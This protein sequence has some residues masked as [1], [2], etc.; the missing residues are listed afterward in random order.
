MC[1]RKEKQLEL[2]LYLQ[3][4]I[5]DNWDTGELRLGP[6]F[7]E[8]INHLAKDE[9]AYELSGLHRPL[10]GVKCTENDLLEHRGPIGLL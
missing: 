9:I 1:F 6:V 7:K 8:N 10:R 5:S 4:S 2:Q 3:G